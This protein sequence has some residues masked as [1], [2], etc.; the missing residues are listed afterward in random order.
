[1]L[2]RSLIAALL[3][4]APA[5]MAQEATTTTDPLA[6]AAECG[7]TAASGEILFESC[8]ACHSTQPDEGV[9]RPGPH[10][11][12]IVGRQIASVDGFPYSDGL[13]AM[14]ADGTEWERDALHAYLETGG[15]GGSHVVVAD[16]QDRRDVMTYMRIATLP[17][18]PAPGEMEISEEVFALAGDPAYGEYLGAE[19]A[20]C[21][22][23]GAAGS[24]VIDGLDRR[25]FITAM[26]EYR[27]R[28]RENE[29]MRLIAARLSD[30]EIAAL[31]AY[32]TDG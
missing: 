21:H 5:A 8:A 24:P 17:P 14:G 26:H 28:A 3:L 2:H 29:T 20:Q 31:A 22:S 4:C 30:E 18:P 23:N 32:F 10:L 9:S 1:M 27:A 7:G 6:I 15:P 16:E 25:Y 19:C 12:G 13:T 11:G